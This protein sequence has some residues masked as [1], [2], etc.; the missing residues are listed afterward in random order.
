MSE[1]DPL[2]KLVK[3]IKQ[4]SVDNMNQTEYSCFSKDDIILLVNTYND[5]FC[6]NNMKQC[7]KNKL[8]T[9]RNENGDK[10]SSKQL[11]KILKKKIE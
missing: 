3:K 9:L 10:R 5:T 4:C 8:I 1:V 11:Y 6:K 7:Y 2:K